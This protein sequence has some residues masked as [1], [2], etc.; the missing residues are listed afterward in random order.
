VENAKLRTSLSGLS[1]EKLIE[2]LDNLFHGPEVTKL[3]QVKVKADGTELEGQKISELLNIEVRSKQNIVNKLMDLAEKNPWFNAILTVKYS[4]SDSENVLNQATKMCDNLIKSNPDVDI[5]E[6]MEVMNKCIEERI[7][8]HDYI[9]AVIIAR[10]ILSGFAR[11]RTRYPAESYAKIKADMFGYYYQA[12]DLAKEKH[13]Y[14]KRLCQSFAPLL[15]MD[16]KRFMDFSL[17]IDELLV[18]LEKGLAQA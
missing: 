17:D 6:K 2:I 15:L 8:S 1:K 10:V 13:E 5:V 7:A 3:V 14:F 11:T 12:F 9:T 18:H 4:Q 16:K